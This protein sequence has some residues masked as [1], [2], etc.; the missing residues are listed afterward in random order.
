[1]LMAIAKQA[2]TIATQAAFAAF[3]F[4]VD[5]YTRPCMVELSKKLL[6]DIEAIVYSEAGLFWSLF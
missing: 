2:T 5:M 1:M 6:I 4:D 3:D